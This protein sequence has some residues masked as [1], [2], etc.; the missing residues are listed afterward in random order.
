VEEKFFLF[1]SRRDDYK[2]SLLLLLR[3]L[4]CSPLSIKGRVYQQ[5]FLGR[6]HLGTTSTYPCLACILPLSTQ[7][8]PIVLDPFLRRVLF[9]LNVFAS[10]KRA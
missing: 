10:W 9:E 8:L 5:C 3:L 4:A 2:C 7:A 6:H 1:L